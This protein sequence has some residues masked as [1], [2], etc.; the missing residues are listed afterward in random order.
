MADT[1]RF[2]CF[3][4]QRRSQWYTHCIDLTLD[5]QADEYAEARAKLDDAIGLYLEWAH[6][7]GLVDGA[8]L[9]RSPLSFRLRYWRARLRQWWRDVRD[10]GRRKRHG[11][12]PEDTFVVTSSGTHGLAA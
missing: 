12:A 4:E 11:E 6:E 9:R 3:A 2:R 1:L 8:E 7:R 5:A 10:G